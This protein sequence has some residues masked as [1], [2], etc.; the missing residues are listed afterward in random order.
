M[1]LFPLLRRG[2]ALKLVDVG[3]VAAT[4][5]FTVADLIGLFVVPANRVAPPPLVAVNSL[6][7]LYVD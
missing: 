3:K 6:R 2:L 1:L 4:E 5:P 7:L